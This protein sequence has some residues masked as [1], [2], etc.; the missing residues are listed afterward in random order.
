[1]HLFENKNPKRDSSTDASSPIRAYVQR[2]TGTS[3]IMEE[4]NG[5]PDQEQIV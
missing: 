1:M 5:V 3:L 2:R 4:D